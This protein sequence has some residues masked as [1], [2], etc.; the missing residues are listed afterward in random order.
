MV[1]ISVSAS[2]FLVLALVTILAGLAHH[3]RLHPDKALDKIVTIL[4]DADPQ[5]K[6]KT[7]SINEITRPLLYAAAQTQNTELP[8][9]LKESIHAHT[10]N[11]ITEQDKRP[12]V[13]ARIGPSFKPY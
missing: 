13:W 1:G 8:D 2:V 6:K 5:Q 4:E 12:S 9:E 7:L 3:R 11:S 10:P